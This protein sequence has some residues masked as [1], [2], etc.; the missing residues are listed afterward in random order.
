M[1]QCALHL[2]LSLKESLD[3]A[4]FFV[5]KGLLLDL[6]SVTRRIGVNY[7]ACHRSF[8]REG[9]MGASIYISESM[10]P[11]LIFLMK[12]NRSGLLFLN[13]CTLRKKLGVSFICMTVSSFS[14]W[15]GI[16]VIQCIFTSYWPIKMCRSSDSSSQHL[17]CNDFDLPYPRV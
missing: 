10:F 4:H 7:C 12:E 6:F 1:F 2:S 9:M 16:G 15:I 8:S 17:C 5:S 11:K 14:K 13:Q 3:E